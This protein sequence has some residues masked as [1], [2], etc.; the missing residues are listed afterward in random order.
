M[1]GLL[2]DSSRNKEEMLSNHHQD[3]TCI[4]TLVVKGEERSFLIR[5]ERGNQLNKAVHSRH[6]LIIYSQNEVSYLETR[7]MEGP[8]RIEPTDGNALIFAETVL[9]KLLGVRAL[10]SA[11]RRSFTAAAIIFAEA[12]KFPILTII[13][14]FLPLRRMVTF[15][16]WPI[17]AFATS[18]RSCW[19]Q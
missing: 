16:S 15:T 3:R 7:S 6:R 12:S 11:P 13:S 1:A 18:F 5:R 9:F 17:G 8:F 10:T 14:S 4:A 19:S 2:S